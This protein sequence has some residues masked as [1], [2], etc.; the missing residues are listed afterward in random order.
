MLGES[1]FEKII[2]DEDGNIIDIIQDLPTD[3]VPEYDDSFYESEGARFVNT[4]S[5]INE[6]IIETKE[7]F[8]TATYELVNL[9]Q[10]ILKK[11]RIS[12]DHRY[13][14]RGLIEKTAMTYSDS[15]DMLEKEKEKTLE[16]KLEEIKESMIKST[17]DD[18][19]NVLTE[20]GTKCWIYRT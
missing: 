12:S 19:L 5:S 9:F 7:Q 18:L 13:T 14:I 15:S 16:E 10:D 8:D 6:Q 11:G 2:R 3:P 20:N 1:D 17:L 4:E